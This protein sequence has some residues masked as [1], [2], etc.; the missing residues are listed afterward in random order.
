[1]EGLGAGEEGEYRAQLAELEAALAG[2]AGLGAGERAELEEAAGALRE[3]LALAAE[4]RAQQ[5]EERAAA[6]GEA[7]GAG[8]GAAAGAAGGVAAGGG[9]GGGGGDSYAPVAAPVRRQGEAAAALPEAPKRNLKILAT[10]SAEVAEKK[11]KQLKAHKSRERFAKMDL[12]HQAKQQGWLAFQAGKKK[13][14]RKPGGGRVPGHL[15]VRPPAAGRKRPY[16]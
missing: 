10:D 13:G 9:G 1:M 16:P 14:A 7:A 2:C 4:V 15:S 11:R 3:V 5:A 6:A 8:A 12:E